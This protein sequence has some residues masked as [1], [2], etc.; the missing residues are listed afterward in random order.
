MTLLTFWIPTFHP[1]GVFFFWFQSWRSAADPE[2]LPPVISFFSPSP[3][4]LRWWSICRSESSACFEELK[5]LKHVLPSLNAATAL[6]A[7]ED[8]QS[9]SPSIRSAARSKPS[10]KQQL[11]E[12][13]V[14]FPLDGSA[15]NAVPHHL[16]HKNDVGGPELWT[17]TPNVR[18]SVFLSAKINVRHY[19]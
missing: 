18:S 10:R 19:N 11:R 1:C 15:W 5:L 9:G 4:T 14:L 3:A 12:R 17:Q 2:L 8:W 16:P 7:A 13:N 6:T